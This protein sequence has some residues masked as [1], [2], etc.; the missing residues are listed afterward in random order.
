M[1]KQKKKKQHINISD[2]WY[3]GLLKAQSSTYSASL[4]LLWSFE[5]V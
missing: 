3:I 4:A 1:F 2:D 5:D